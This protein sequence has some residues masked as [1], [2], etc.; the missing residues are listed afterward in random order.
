MTDK[1]DGNNNDVKKEKKR[2]TFLNSGF[3]ETRLR[4]I[5]PVS[6][7]PSLFC[8]YSNCTTHSNSFIKRAVRFLLLVY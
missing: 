8:T 4:K 5:T 6:L 2:K 1:Q 7:L 3:H